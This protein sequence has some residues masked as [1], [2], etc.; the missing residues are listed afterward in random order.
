MEELQSPQVSEHL[1]DAIKQRIAS[2][3]LTRDTPLQLFAGYGTGR[4]CCGGCGR[5]I[6][7]TE[8][9]WEVEFAIG[10]TIM[11]HRDCHAVWKVECERRSP[12]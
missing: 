9:E 5:N 8:L 12:A 10:P 3:E 7:A 1:A 11:F 4:H 6:A 2:G